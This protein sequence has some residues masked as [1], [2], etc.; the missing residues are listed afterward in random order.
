MLGVTGG[1]IE[2]NSGIRERRWVETCQA[3]SE[4]AVAAIS[5]ALNDAGARAEDVDYLI[6]C[7]LSPDY[8]VPGIAPIIQ[9]K[10]GG[11]RNIPSI[12]L[13]AGCA[14]ILYS[15]QL[16]RG[17][18]ESRAARTVVCCGAEAQSK[19]LDLNP[20]S[21]DL[22]MLFGD[23]AGAFVL[24]SALRSAQTERECLVQVDDILIETDGSFAE[25]L[26]V[27]APGTDNGAPRILAEQIVSGCSA[28]IA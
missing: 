10:L 9:H 27:R 12:D 3:T 28:G 4:L 15:L 23:G 14:S 5:N 11:C 8:Q 25:D 19:G 7:T 18:I 26:N 21:A 24:S 16:A 17:L 22:S 1:W 6:A 13:R 2:A 20:R